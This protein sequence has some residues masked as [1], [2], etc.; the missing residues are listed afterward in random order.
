VIRQRICQIPD[1]LLVCGVRH[2]SLEHPA[3]CRHQLLRSPAKSPG[4]WQ[5]KSVPSSKFEVAALLHMLDNVLQILLWLQNNLLG[6]PGKECNM[7]C[8]SQLFLV[9]DA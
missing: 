7:I 9:L 3:S 8:R 5:W 2:L 4:L 1:V 6:L